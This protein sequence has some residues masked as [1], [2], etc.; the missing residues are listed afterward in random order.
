M[1]NLVVGVD[2]GGTKIEAI[3][4]DGKKV[5]K[6]V[7]I[8]TQA[9]KSYATVLGNIVKAVNAVR[10]KDVVAVGI[11][12]PGAVD[13]EGILHGGPNT[14]CLQQKAVAKD[15]S[16]KVKLPTVQEND[17]KCFAL[18]EAAV[19]AGK[20]KTYVVGVIVG[21]GVSCGL[22]VNGRIYRGATGSAGELGHAPFNDN[23]YEYYCSGP[24]TVNSYNAFGGK[25]SMTTEKILLTKT[26]TFATDEVPKS[27]ESAVLLAQNYTYDSLA[28]FSATVIRAYNPEVIVFGGGV[29]KSL[30]FDRLKKRTSLYLKEKHLKPVKFTRYALSDSAGA[31]GA[32]MLA[33]D[34]VKK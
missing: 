3:L 27:E 6:K 22:V 17:S 31:I 26:K 2:L 29:S 20:G 30:D 14:K 7:R 4:F 11:S 1:K 13:S 19:G 9:D 21:T 32:G 33:F 5:L 15:V 34:V 23:D 18:A 28:R 8:P 24:G 12:S 10:T 16:K 25:Q